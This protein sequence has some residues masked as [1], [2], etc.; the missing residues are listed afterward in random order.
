MRNSAGH[1]AAKVAEF[2]IYSLA[3]AELLVGGPL[4]PGR[5]SISRVGSKVSRDTVACRHNSV[6]ESI[7]PDRRLFFQQVIGQPTYNSLV[8]GGASLDSRTKAATAKIPFLIGAGKLPQ[9]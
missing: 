5:G 6:S 8:R 1:D 3:S 7:K 4:V 9:A 2:H